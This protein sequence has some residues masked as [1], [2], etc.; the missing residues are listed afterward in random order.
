VRRV[1]AVLLA[2]ALLSAGT[3]ILASA[4]GASS[5]ALPT[6]SGGFGTS[7]TIHFPSSQPPTTLVTKVLYKGSGPVVDKGELVAVNYTGQIW[8]G[9]VFDSTF[10]KQ[11]DHQALFGAPLASG[12]VITGWIDGLAGTRVGS[13]VLLVIPPSDGYG[14]AGQSGAGITGTDTIVFVVDE[15]AAYTARASAD[16]HA[17]IETLSHA[18][19]RVSGAL[20]KVPTITIAKSA[21]Q[22]S[23][24]VT[25]VLAKGHGPKVKAG[26]V[27]FQS[28][29]VEWSGAVVQSSWQQ[30]TPSGNDVGLASEPS[31]LNALIGIPIGS[32][33]LVEL[34]KTSSGGPYAGVVDIV[35]EPSDPAAS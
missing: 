26:L 21:R 18:G 14:S 2:T 24:Q 19:V 8:R 34:P 27:V 9:K 7:P 35:A 11:F 5:T 16:P 22:P 31:A 10:Q 30:G 6:V 20:G 29:I 3:V 33:V 13:R 17:S 32:R 4:S 1:T 15:V 25:V 12:G 28:K 23:S